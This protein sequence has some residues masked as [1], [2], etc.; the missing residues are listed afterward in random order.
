MAAIPPSPPPCNAAVLPAFSVVL[1]RSPAYLLRCLVSIQ[2]TDCDLC[3][4]CRCHAATHC[5]S[6]RTGAAD[7]FLI[8][9]NIRSTLLVSCAS[10]YVIASWLLQLA[11][12]LGWPLVRF[13]HQHFPWA[14][15]KP[16]T[17]CPQ[18][19]PQGTGRTALMLAAAKGHV[20]VVRLLLQKGADGSLED[21]VGGFRVTYTLPELQA[22]V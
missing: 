4:E 14:H 1:F 7:Q 8:S 17:Y 9:P 21:K 15:S 11:S 18:M 3:D 6:R 2:K 16:L 13:N 22:Q 10:L 12:L 5:N 19:I 20:E